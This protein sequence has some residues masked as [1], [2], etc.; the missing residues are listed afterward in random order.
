MK[1][2]ATLHDHPNDIGENVL[3]KFLNRSMAIQGQMDDIYKGDP[4]LRDPLNESIDIPVV[5][6]YLKEGPA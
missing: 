1:L 3:Q 2:T 4:Y 5:R 6:G